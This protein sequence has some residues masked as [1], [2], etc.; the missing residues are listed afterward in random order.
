MKDPAN[1]SAVIDILNDLL[2]VELNSVFQL[3]GDSDIYM[4]RSNAAFRRPLAQM[5]AASPRRA[6]ELSKLID[7]LGGIPI[8]RGLQAAEQNV[9]YLSL[10]FLLPRLVAAKE[11]AIA[12]WETAIKTFGDRSR[13]ATLLL[14]KHL[15]EHR[16]HLSLLQKIADAEHPDSPI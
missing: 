2:D 6:S 15:T 4:D 3:L 9:A 12:R 1:Q 7:D 13:E 10:K 11:L 16:F 14:S 5:L 8:P